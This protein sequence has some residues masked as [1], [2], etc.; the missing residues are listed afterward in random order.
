[1][2]YCL[3]ICYLL[4]Y[5]DIQDDKK[6]FNMH[7]SLWSSR[8]GRQM[9]LLGIQHKYISYFVI[10]PLDKWHSKGFIESEEEVMI[11]I[12]QEDFDHFEELSRHFDGK[13]RKA[14]LSF[15]LKEVCRAAGEVVT[16]MQIITSADTEASNPSNQ[17]QILTRTM[18]EQAYMAS[19]E[20]SA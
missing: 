9:C 11:F 17:H 10:R 14:F 1:M 2:K 20:V 8:L 15:F 12:R 4:R 16:V 7:I 18:I 13:W 5:N 6:I 19:K 3:D